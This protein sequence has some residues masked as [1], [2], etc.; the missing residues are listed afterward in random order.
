MRYAHASLVEVD[1]VTAGDAKLTRDTSTSLDWLDANETTNISYNDIVN[2][3]GN[4]WVSQGFRHATL[5]E[6][7]D[8][9][10]WAGWNGENTISPQH[11]DFL[12]MLT[13]Y[14]GSSTIIGG[15]I[16][17]LYLVTATPWDSSQTLVMATYSNNGDDDR[18]AAWYQQ[19]RNNSANNISH[20]LVRAT[21][22]QTPTPLP[23]TAAL[24]PIGV[25][26][27]EWRRRRKI[28]FLTKQT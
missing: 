14:L 23:P 25:A 3:V 18:V 11:N 27:M 16:F 5:S 4:D 13:G 15:S 7:T 8:L 6:V 21:P 19:G 9:F 22:P 26:F 10:T 2:G 12:A 28:S 24:F 20:A 1:L 17:Q